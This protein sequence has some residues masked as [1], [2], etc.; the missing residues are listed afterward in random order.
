V[1]DEEK[2]SGLGSGNQALRTLVKSL[3]TE[4]GFLPCGGVGFVQGEEE[5]GKNRERDSY[6]VQIPKKS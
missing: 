1:K 6:F 4:K 5:R 2:K 3:R